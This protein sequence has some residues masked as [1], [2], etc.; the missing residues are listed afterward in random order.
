MVQNSLSA[1]LAGVMI[2]GCGYHFQGTGSLPGNTET[3]FVQVI[4]NRTSETGIENVFTAALI[5][6]L[7]RNQRAAGQ[8]RADALLSGEI[9]SVSTVTISRTGS[10]TSVE[11]RVRATLNLALTDRSGVVIWKAR[12]ISATEAFPVDADSKARTDQNRREA[13]T[14]LAQRMAENIYNR[15]TDDF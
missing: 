9:A 14:Q 6:E 2:V 4:N 13:L 8:D 11:R 15:M 10:T 7:T 3:V 12:N 5:D 1:L